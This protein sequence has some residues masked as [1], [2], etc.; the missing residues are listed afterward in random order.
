[1]TFADTRPAR[2]RLPRGTWIATVTLVGVVALVLVERGFREMEVRLSGVI[3]Q[4]L[5]SEGVFVAGE[6]EAVYFGLSGPSPLGLRMTPECS[7][8]YMLLPLLLVTAV[9]AWLRKGRGRRLLVSLGIACVAVILVN[10]LRVLTIVGLV[11]WLGT[12]RGYYWGHTLLG[13]LVSVIGGAVALVLF[14][15]LVT[16]RSRAEAGGTGA[17]ARE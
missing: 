9:L 5:T 16:R 10:Q 4:L 2:L 15:W 12:D 13:S 17:G 7:S 1:M 6:R 11:D 3:L 8:L 14:V